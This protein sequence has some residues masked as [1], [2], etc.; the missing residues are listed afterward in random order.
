VKSPAQI[1]LWS[2]SVKTLNGLMSYS[3]LREL[4][5]FA[6]TPPSR[7][8]R[9]PHAWLLWTRL[10]ASLCQSRMASPTP[11]AAGPGVK[12]RALNLNR[13]PTKLRKVADVL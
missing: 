6:E 7:R 10:Q 4:L 1:L 12:E 8:Y 3:G 2:A 11:T 5:V 9:G 13:T